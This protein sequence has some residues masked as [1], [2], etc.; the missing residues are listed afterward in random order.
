M[1]TSKEEGFMAD[2]SELKVTDEERALIDALSLEIEERMT[3]IQKVIMRRLDKNATA[4]SGL[5]SFSV[6]LGADATPK[7]VQ[8]RGAVTRAAIIKVITVQGPGGCGVYRDPPG[9]C[10]PCCW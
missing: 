5:D 10:E 8:G 3:K 4:E 6:N 9:I 1:S 2:K 7:R